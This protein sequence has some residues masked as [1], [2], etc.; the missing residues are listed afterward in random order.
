MILRTSLAILGFGMTLGTAQPLLG[1]DEAI[2]L[3]IRNNH[4]LSL[5]RDE[6]DVAANARR[7][8]TGEFL[9]SASAGI[10]HSGRFDRETPSTGIE[11]S[12]DFEIFDGMRDYHGFRR[13]KSQEKS[14]ILGERIAVENLVESVIVSYYDIVQQ[15]QRLEAIR[16]LLAVSG[17]RAR[18]AQ[19]KLEIGAGSRLEQ[20]QSLTDLNEDSSTF[21]GQDASL[22][23]S[24]ISLNHLLAREASL[25]FDVADSIPLETAL[26]LDEWRRTLPDGNAAIA[27]ARER[28]NAAQS[29]L[30][31]ARGGWLPRLT[32]GV[33][34][35]ETPEAW[36]SGS[37]LGNR[38]GFSY[39]IRLSVPLF[40]QLSTPTA[41]RRARIDMR[42]GE[43]RLR[44]AES[45]T[46]RDFELAR[47]GYETGL[48]QVALEE[49]NL[50][51]AR[52]QAEAAQE[53]YKVGVSS[54]LEFR[55]AQ[56]RLL[57]AE[58][59]LITARQTAKQSEAALRRL[60]GALIRETPAEGK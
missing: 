31:E 40:D 46:A 38:D 4:S 29:A 9:P 55:D 16:D 35:T 25:E 1:L 21:L 54:A 60:A 26:P 37:N 48:R 3:A 22:R 51:V 53:R 56:T 14:A 36:N 12:V 20:L 39:N 32:S 42:S 19:A 33:S 47:M 7:G 49:R 44:L 41:V 52:L 28:R 30:G 23:E 27:A 57:D 13:L 15:K 5:T 8:G 11:G 18:L 2:A 34:Y 43:T 59:R 6:T 17:E 10:S 50:Q 58:V 45:E 24:K